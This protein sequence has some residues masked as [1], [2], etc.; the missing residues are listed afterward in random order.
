[1]SFSSLSSGEIYILWIDHVLMAHHQRSMKHVKARWLPA[2]VWDHVSA[3]VSKKT[4]RSFVN[5]ML[6]RRNMSF[7]NPN[8]WLNITYMWNVSLVCR[9]HILPTFILVIRLVKSEP[10]NTWVKTTIFLSCSRLVFSC[11]LVLHFHDSA[12]TRNYINIKQIHIHNQWRHTSCF[13]IQTWDF[14]CYSDPQLTW[15]TAW[16]V[17]L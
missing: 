17:I 1:M 10:V 11:L 12:H 7:S 5:E 15:F 6:L 4:V 9:K 14:R 13:T 8:M 3:F 2:T 16:L